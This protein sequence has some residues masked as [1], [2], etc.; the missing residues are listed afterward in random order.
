[1]ISLNP[2]ILSKLLL[3]GG[4]GIGYFYLFIFFPNHGLSIILKLL[5][6]HFNFFFFLI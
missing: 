4:W 5:R 1:M 2:F 3:F 6:R